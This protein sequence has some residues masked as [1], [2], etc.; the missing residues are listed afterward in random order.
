MRVGRSFGGYKAAT[1]TTLKVKSPDG[2]VRNLDIPPGGSLPKNAR[3]KKRP[4]LAKQGD[5]NPG[6]FDDIFEWTDE[7]GNLMTA[8][9]AKGCNHEKWSASS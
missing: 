5:P 4:D 1:K 3:I 6:K 8:T 7:A 9:I 2:T